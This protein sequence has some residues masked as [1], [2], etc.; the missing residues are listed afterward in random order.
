MSDSNEQEPL[1]EEVLVVSDEDEQ[2]EELLPLV[3]AVMK[4]VSDENSGQGP[5]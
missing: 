5:K 3:A 2:E 4:S 1:E